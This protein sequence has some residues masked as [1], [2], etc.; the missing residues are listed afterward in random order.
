MPNL[1]RQTT[2]QPICLVEEF[3]PHI[4]VQDNYINEKSL[5][6]YTHT[7]CTL[8]ELIIFAGFAT[9]KNDAIK[10]IQ[11]GQVSVNGIVERRNLF[12]FEKSMFKYKILLVR[13]FP[14]LRFI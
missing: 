2:R 12:Y 6:G 5:D 7:L 4:E 9:S 11:T 14:A 3:N 1:A 13:G 10:K 8:D